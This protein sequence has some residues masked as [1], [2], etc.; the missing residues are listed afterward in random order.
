VA[1]TVREPAAADCRPLLV[2]AVPPASAAPL[3]PR[4]M[5]FAV[6]AYPTVQIVRFLTKIA[7][8]RLVAAEVFG[9]VMFAGLIVSLAAMVALFGLDDAL[10]V[11]KKVDAGLWARLRR[12]HHLSGL[13]MALVTAVVGLLMPTMLTEYPH[14]DDYMLA[15]APT[16]WLANFAILPTALLVR[17]RQYRR[18]FSIDVAGVVCL[19]TV[20]I[21]AAR[22]GCQGWSMVAG[23]Y[24]GGAAVAIL[25]HRFARPY[26]P[27]ESA[28]GDDWQ[29]TVDY[30][31]TMCGAKLLGF[32]GERMDT[33]IIGFSRFGRAILGNYELAS[34]IGGFLTNFTT[35][36]NERWLFPMLAAQDDEDGRRPLGLEMLRFTNTF[37]LPAYVVLAVC[38]QPLIAVLVKDASWDTAAQ[39]LAIISLSY[40]VRCPDIVAATALKAAGY[41]RL[42]LN[43]SMLTLALLIVLPLVFLHQGVMAVALAAAAA[44]A[45]GGFVTVCVALK[46]LRLLKGESSPAMRTGTTTLVA[47]CA[48]FLPAAW[49]LRNAAPASP[50]IVLASTA[51]TAAGFWAAIRL[52][53][54]RRTLLREWS[55]VRSRISAPSPSR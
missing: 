41:E 4:G 52:V 48:A 54:E 7:L 26:V 16:V 43:R 18:V 37:L 12:T 35:S 31:T 22:L 29:K 38:A 25:A 8:A 28:G 27:R 24:A 42:V 23:W 33:L 2:A 30:G 44:R 3:G 46:K 49:F 50:G 1:Q 5:R 19:A 34:H 11:A 10:V 15:L 45:I 9:E 53:V 47:W 55:F 20:T 17:H 32:F 51:C 36:L 14:L 40:A 13:F 39:L 6:L 21:V